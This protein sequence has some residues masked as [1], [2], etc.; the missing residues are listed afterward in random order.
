MPGVGPARRARLLKAF[1]SV[2]ALRQATAADVAVRARIPMSLAERVVAALAT[3]P[4]AG[5]AQR[6]AGGA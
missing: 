3:A 1:G 2:A 5:D 6:R 4:E